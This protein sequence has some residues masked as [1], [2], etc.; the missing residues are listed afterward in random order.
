MADKIAIRDKLL[1][2]LGTG[3]LASA[4]QY[5]DA[6]FRVLAAHPHPHAGDY[7]GMQGLSKM[8]E[9]MMASYA[10]ER[11]E[12]LEVFEGNNPDEVVFRFAL[13]GKVVSTGAPFRTTALEFWTFRNDKIAMIVPYWFEI[14]PQ[15]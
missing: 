11:L 10:F 12:P 14:P 6:D 4:S 3:E 15:R 9:I 13:E 2:V 8:L 1:Q 7:H 5:I